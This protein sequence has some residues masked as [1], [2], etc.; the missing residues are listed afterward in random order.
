MLQ[1]VFFCLCLCLVLS[2]TVCLSPTLPFLLLFPLIDQFCNDKRRLWNF[3]LP[4]QPPT[5]SF[6]FLILFSSCEHVH[7]CARISMSSRA[8][9]PIKQPPRARAPRDQHSLRKMA[10]LCDASNEQDSYCLPPPKGMT[11][12]PA[13]RCFL[14][15]A[16]VQRE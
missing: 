6:V 13:W 15:W 2:L 16:C 5:H 9:A 11:W 8:H 3:G 1:H 4:S 14:N 12:R 7:R 10:D